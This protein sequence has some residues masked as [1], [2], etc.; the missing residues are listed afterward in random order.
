MD[1]FASLV[2]INVMR[3]GLSGDSYSPSCLFIWFPHMSLHIDPV[4]L[5]VVLDSDMIP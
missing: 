3:I 4:L 1:Y 2:L 5:Q